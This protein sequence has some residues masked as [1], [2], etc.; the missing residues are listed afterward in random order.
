MF[1][2]HNYVDFMLVFV[3]NNQQLDS[4]HSSLSKGFY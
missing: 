1:F 4:S 2:T 3:W